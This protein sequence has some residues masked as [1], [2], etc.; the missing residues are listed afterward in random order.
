MLSICCWQK[1]YHD[2]LEATDAVHNG[3]LS[4]M[5]YFSRNFSESLWTRM[6]NFAG[7]DEADIVAGQIQVSLDMGGM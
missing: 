1:Y 7:A 5:I 2:V 3:K 6:E 4:G